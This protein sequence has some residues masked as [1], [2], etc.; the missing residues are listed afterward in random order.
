MLCAR[1][2]HKGGAGAGRCVRAT[3]TAATL[4]QIT[5]VGIEVEKLTLTPDELRQ[6]LLKMLETGSIPGVRCFW[7]VVG[8]GSA[9]K[10][11]R[12]LLATVTAVAIG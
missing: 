12:I 9:G 8:R 5:G 10:N 4:L 6:S 1:Q 7:S 3:R 2:D 11:G